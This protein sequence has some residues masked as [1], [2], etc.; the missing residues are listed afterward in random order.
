MLLECS[1]ARRD[2]FYQHESFRDDLD[3]IIITKVPLG[4]KLPNAT[5]EQ[6]I[7]RP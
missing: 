3:D 5:K 1:N 4:S 7:N 2:D 6:I